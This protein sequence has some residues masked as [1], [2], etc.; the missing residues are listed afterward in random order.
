MYYICGTNIKT[1][2]RY[3]KAPNP[4]LEMEEITSKDLFEIINHLGESNRD[5][6]SIYEIISADDSDTLRYRVDCG[7]AG[8]FEISKHNGEEEYCPR[9]QDWVWVEG[10]I[11]KFS[12]LSTTYAGYPHIELFRAYDLINKP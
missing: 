11:Y 5:G 12:C 10:T 7:D 6:Y 1:M 3:R 8:S 4:D 2:K 9:R